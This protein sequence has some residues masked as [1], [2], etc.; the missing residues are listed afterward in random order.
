VLAPAREGSNSFGKTGWGA[1]CPPKGD[2]RHRYEFDLY[3][4]RRPLDLAAGARPAAVVNAIA[5]AAGG[6]GRL[7]GRYERR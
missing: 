5:A 4:V 6:H 3:W 7:T 2:G 1:P